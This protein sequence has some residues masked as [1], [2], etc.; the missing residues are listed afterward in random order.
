MSGSF[1]SAK[2]PVRKVGPREKVLKADDFEL[3]KLIGRGA[4]GDV[5]LCRRKGTVEPIYALK[6]MRKV[7]MY[8]KKQVMHVKSERNVLAAVQSNNDWIVRLHF[9][10]TDSDRL[11]MVMDYM[12]GG[13]MMTWLIEKEVFT[14]QET[15]FYIAELCAAVAS[16][17]D[18]RYVHRDIKPDNILLDATGHIKLSDFGLCKAFD[19]EPEADAQ[20]STES[21]NTPTT[22]RRKMFT[23]FVGSPGYIAPEILQ[24]RPYGPECDWWSVGVI[25]YEMLFGYPPFYSEDNSE[26]CRRIV[27][28]RDFLVFPTNTRYPVPADAIDLMRGLLTDAERRLTFESIKQHPFFRS[29][30]WSEL[31]LMPA[32]FQPRLSNPLDT[33]YFPPIDDAPPQSAAGAAAGAALQQEDP[34]GVLFAGFGFNR[35]R[36][37][38]YGSAPNPSLRS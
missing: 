19:E 26:T 30:N 38:Y 31:K 21:G 14:T 32:A 16:V 34:R 28:W 4:F 8:R 29:F 12:P 27:A 20:I 23:S 3:L 18:M 25:M 11:Y 15:K 22:D 36:V 10:F 2:G 24:R 17:H 35:E 9:S 7:D 1:G 37:H 13:D 6:T 5:Q 33:R